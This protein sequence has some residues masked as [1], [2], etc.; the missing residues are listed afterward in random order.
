[1]KRNPGMLAVLSISPDYTSFHPGYTNANK[2]SVN[3]FI[4]PT[5]FMRD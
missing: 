1:M 5:A 3:Q 4:M 2:N